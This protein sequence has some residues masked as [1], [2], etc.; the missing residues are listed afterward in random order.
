M[1]AQESWPRWHCPTHGGLLVQQGNDLCCPSGD[2]FPIEDGIPRFVASQAYTA[3]FGSQWNHFKS[4]QLDSHTGTSISKDRLRRCMGDALWT[5]LR[6]KQIL[7]CGCGAGRFTEL[8]VQQGAIV[9]SIDMSEAVVAN[10]D[11][12]RSPRHRVAQADLF[13][14][15]FAPQEFDVVLC[16]GV[17]QHTPDTK[18][19]LQHLYGNVRPGGHL[20]VD[21][22]RRDWR[23]YTTLSPAFRFVMRRLSPERA[24][25]WNEKLVRSLFPAHVRVRS[26]IGKL[27][28]AR[29]SPVVYYG[30]QYPQLG[31]K[32]L[33]EWSLLDTH[34]GLT[35][36]YKR[37][38]SLEDFRCMLH[39][40]GGT[41]V[42]CEP[43]GNGIEA[44]LRRP[45]GT[46]SGRVG[47]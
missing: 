4:T 29:F 46:I 34:D 35:D 8:L 11:N 2:R 40:L 39:E 1:T 12:V 41:D 31:P 20:V 36:Q 28:L 27:L 17:I 13:R 26:R 5:Q 30:D 18:Q 32:Q 19:A 37:L 22:Y 16:L 7:E 3:H 21:H 25:Q 38:V 15:P 42:W 14:L 44:R 45:E 47:T 23:R 43:G 24:L 33:Y 10:R 9:T 6:N